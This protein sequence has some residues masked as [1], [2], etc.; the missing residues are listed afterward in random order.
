[1][2]SGNSHD[3]QIAANRQELAV[4]KHIAPEH[5]HA[6]LGG[7][8]CRRNGYDVTDNPYESAAA[9]EAWRRGFVEAKNDA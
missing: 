6:Y 5:R 4:P 3:E 8:W 9:A 2:S 1:M 7:V